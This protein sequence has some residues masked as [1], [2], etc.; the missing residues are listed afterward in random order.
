MLSE[1]N[2]NELN[3]LIKVARGEQPAELILADVR[4][5]N[6]FT[7]EIERANVAI[8]GGR[9]A[10][11]GNYRR[12]KQIRD[13]Q[14]KYLAPTLL[15]GHI[16][17]ES[18]LLSLPQYTRA[19]V[20]HGTGAVVTDL[21]EIANVS[22][23][24]G[25]RY[26]LNL[27]SDLPLSL[28]LMVPSCVPATKKETS[29]TE[30]GVDDTQVMLNWEGV[31]GLGE[32][33]SFPSVLAGDEEILL[34]L[35]ISQDKVIDGH[36]PGLSGMD[37]NAYLT[38]G[39]SSDHES[40]ALKEGE[41]KLRRGMFLM[42]REGSSAKN[43]TALL[44][45]VNDQTYPRCLFVIDDRSC[46]DLLEDGDV[47]AVVRKAIQEGLEPIRAIQLATI[48][49]ARYFGLKGYG[50]IAPGYFADLMTINDLE[51]FDIDMVFYHGELV[52]EKGKPLFSP[53][54]MTGEGLRHTVNI[55]PVDTASL[56]IP[57]RRKNEPIIEIVPGQIV[58][59]KRYEEPKIAEGLIVSDVDRDILKL[60]VVERHRASGNIGLGLVKGF[61]LKR[62]ALATSYA[63]DSHN[64]VVVGTNDAD[65]LVAISG[66]VGLEGGLVVAAD[67][68]ILGSLALPQA[69]L[70]SD[71]P[72]ETVV[73]KLKHLEAIAADLG[74]SLSSPFTTLSFLALPVIPEL[75][76]TDLG[77][78]EV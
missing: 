42:I 2:Y 43:L 60:A 1:M 44:P 21:H 3:K 59:R 6:T 77:L 61:G 20:P 56:G 17:I 58:T 23:M 10:G 73:D 25:M 63:H 51:K 40:V 71:E 32:V 33:M 45:L 37:L 78:V 11:I 48:N 7:G 29:A 19:V 30:L 35:A 46:V 14:G 74:C 62:G 53:P 13:L 4:I 39:I 38:T 12:A 55:K 22:G 50:A 66:V 64:L 49:P 67:G 24:E 5:V 27:A 75:R 31:L 26:F 65:I 28:F 18:S 9:I 47:D 52:A 15:D 54:E 76:L 57:A 36:A 34:K 68:E 16:H 69:G 70:L 72:L 8:Q 41:E